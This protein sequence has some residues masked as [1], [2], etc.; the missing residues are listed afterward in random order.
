MRCNTELCDFAGALVA[1]CLRDLGAYNSESPVERFVWTAD[2][3]AMMYVD[4]QTGV[5]N[6]WTQPI[7]G[8]PPEELTNFKSGFIFNFATS[9][10]SKTLAC[11]RGSLT[12]D[13]VLIQDIK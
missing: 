2:G 13:V 8:G 12:N 11:A 9:R 6:I 5:S 4:T 1:N 3:G 7:A 10:D